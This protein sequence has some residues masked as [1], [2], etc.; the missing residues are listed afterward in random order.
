M[1]ISHDIQKRF[2]V[3]RLEEG[4]VRSKTD[5]FTE[6]KNLILAHEGMYPDIEKWFRSKVCPGVRST[7]RAAFVGYLDQK[8]VVSAVV[9]RGE[10]AKFCHLHITQGL[11]EA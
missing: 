1:E 9:K 10:N 7:E 5:H 2:Q 11:R 8:P 6:L 4:D 3:V